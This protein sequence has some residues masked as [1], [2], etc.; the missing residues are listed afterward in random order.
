MHAFGL[1]AFVG[2][3]LAVAGTAL[4]TGCLH[5]DGL[6]TRRTVSVPAGLESASSRSCA[7]ARSALTAPRR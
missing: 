7:T 5:E 2:A 1:H 4:I 3:A 6:R